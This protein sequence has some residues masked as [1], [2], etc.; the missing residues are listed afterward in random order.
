MTNLKTGEAK[1]TF[2]G[3]LIFDGVGFS[4]VAVGSFG[5]LILVDA[6]LVNLYEFSINWRF[7][8]AEFRS[9]SEESNNGILTSAS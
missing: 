7:S 5:M 1:L 9:V 2:T 3:R 6:V 8:S 4:G